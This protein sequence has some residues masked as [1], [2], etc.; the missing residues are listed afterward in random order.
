[1]ECFTRQG[2]EFLDG[3]SEEEKARLIAHAVSPSEFIG[4]AVGDSSA[5]YAEPIISGKDPDLGDVFYYQNV[6]A[7]IAK[8]VVERYGPGSGAFV[9]DQERIKDIMR[10]SGYMARLLVDE[11]IG[12]GSENFQPG[13]IGI[14]VRSLTDASDAYNDY[15][16]AVAGQLV[17]PD[18]VPQ[19]MREIDHARAMEARARKDLKAIRLIQSRREDVPLGEFAQ[20]QGEGGRL[21]AVTIAA[22]IDD[23]RYAEP[24]APATAE[25]VPDMTKPLNSP[26]PPQ[27]SPVDFVPERAKV[28]EF[29]N[30]LQNELNKLGYGAALSPDD[31][32]AMRVDAADGGAMN[33]SRKTS[34]G[35]A[36][37]ND[38]EVLQSQYSDGSADNLS[39]PVDPEV[40]DG[41]VDDAF[42]VDAATGQGI[43]ANASV[44]T[45]GSVRNRLLD[46]NDKIRRDIKAPSLLSI[47]D[48][49]YRGRLDQLRLRLSEL[50]VGYDRAQL[51][52]IVAGYAEMMKPFVSENEA[53][54][55]THG[56]KT[57]S[58]PA[59]N[60]LLT[61]DIDSSVQNQY[62]GKR[63]KGKPLYDLLEAARGEGLFPKTGA[64]DPSKEA[65]LDL[66]FT[67]SSGTV[68]KFVE[69][70]LPVLYPSKNRN[71]A[72]NPQ[73]AAI[74]DELREM[75][76]L[77]FV[78]SALEEEFQSLNYIR[79]DA[80]AVVPI[81]V[82]MFSDAKMPTTI[83]QEAPRR[84]KAAPT[85][86]QASVVVHFGSMS[87]ESLP[88]A[89]HAAF[90]DPD[91]ET[92]VA[93]KSMLGELSVGSSGFAYD[94]KRGVVAVDASNT[95]VSGERTYQGF[96]RNLVA[97]LRKGGAKTIHVPFHIVGDT[98][99]S[100]ADMRVSHELL[101]R[102]DSELSPEESALVSRY[103]QE[104]DKAIQLGILDWPVKRNAWLDAAKLYPDVE[105]NIYAPHFKV[106]D[107]WADPDITKQTYRQSAKF[108]PSLKK[109]KKPLASSEL[110][111]SMIS[112]I[113][114]GK[115]LENQDAVSY[116]IGAPGSRFLRK[117]LDEQGVVDEF[118]DLVRDYKF[119]VREVEELVR[120][121]NLSDP[122]KERWL[123][124]NPL[125]R[126]PFAESIVNSGRATQFLEQA[127]RDV[128]AIEGAIKSSGLEARRNAGPPSKEY[129]EVANAIAGI[130]DAASTYVANVRDSRMK[131]G[132]RD[133][134]WRG[135]QGERLVDF[136]EEP[137]IPQD[138]IRAIEGYVRDVPTRPGVEEDRKRMLLAL[139]GRLE[140][141]TAPLRYREIAE[142][143]DV[144]K[145][146]ERNFSLQKTIGGQTRWA[147]DSAADDNVIFDMEGST[148]APRS[149]IPKF[150]GRKEE[151]PQADF[152]VR[153]E[154]LPGDNVGEIVNAGEW[155]FNVP[156]VASL[157]WKPVMPGQTGVSR[158]VVNQRVSPEAID[159]KRWMIV[160][161]PHYAD[162]VRTAVTSAGGDDA[163]ASA[164][165]ARVR[166]S[167]LLIAST[168]IARIGEKLRGLNPDN[169]VVPTRLPNFGFGLGTTKANL[170]RA[171][172][173]MGVKIANSPQQIAKSYRSLAKD[174]DV[175][176]VYYDGQNRQVK[177][178]INSAL[179]QDKPLI[180][181]HTTPP[182]PGSTQ[183]VANYENFGVTAFEGGNE[184][185]IGS[186]VAR[187]RRVFVPE[188]T[189]LITS[190]TDQS[191]SDP[192]LRHFTA[193]VALNRG[194][195]F[196]V[197]PQ[198]IGRPRLQ[199]SSERV[200]RKPSEGAFFDPPSYSTGYNKPTIEPSMP[201]FRKMLQDTASFVASN[202]TP[203]SS[204]VVW[205]PVPVGY[206][207]PG[208]DFLQGALD[209]VAMVDLPDGY[210]W[211][212]APPLSIMSKPGAPSYETAPYAERYGAQPGRQTNFLG[213]SDT[214]LKVNP[215]ALS[216][217]RRG[218]STSL[219]ARRAAVAELDS[220]LKSSD[221]PR[222]GLNKSQTTRSPE[223]PL[224]SGIRY[225]GET[226]DIRDSSAEAIVN[227]VNVKG[228]MGK[229]L[230]LQMKERWPEMFKAYKSA[231]D[232]G[233]LQIGRMHV[234]VNKASE[235]PR[236]IINFPTKEE[237]GKPSKIEYID[238]GLDALKKELGRLGVKSVAIPKLGSG[239]GGLNW[240]DV[241]ARINA[242][243]GN[244]AGLRVDV[245]ASKAAPEPMVDAPT[246]KTTEAKATEGSQSAAAKPAR[247]PIS[248][249]EP[250]RSTVSKATTGTV[251]QDWRLSYPP[252]LTKNLED[253]DI[254]GELNIIGKD[255]T[256]FQ[257]KAIAVVGSRDASPERINYAR[258]LGVRAAERDVVVVSGLARGVDQAAMLGALESGGR[259]IG[260]AAEGADRI[261]SSAK[262]KKYV[263]NGQLT[264]VSDVGW[265]GD[266]STQNAFRRNKYI[267]GLADSAIVVE[268]DVASGGTKAGVDWLKSYPKTEASYPLYVPHYYADSPGLS[269]IKGK[270]TSVK[271]L[272]EGYVSNQ[273]TT[274]KPDFAAKSEQAAEGAIVAQAPDNIRIL[275][276][277]GMSPSQY[278]QHAKD[279]GYGVVVDTRSYTEGRFH[280]EAIK[281]ELA[282][283]GIAY[284]HVVEFGGKFAGYSKEAY[285]E[286]VYDKRAKEIQPRVEKFFAWAENNDQKIGLMCA[287]KGAH[288]CHNREIFG[289]NYGVPE[290]I[291]GKTVTYTGGAKPG[292]GS[293][294]LY[295][296]LLPFTADALNRP[297]VTGA[298]ARG[299]VGWAIGFYAPAIFW[300]DE[301]EV[302]GTG[303][304]GLQ[305]RVM[306][307]AIGAGGYAARGSINIPKPAM[308]IVPG[309]PIIS[310]HQPKPVQGWLAKA[311]GAAL[312]YLSNEDQTS[313]NNARTF[314]AT[315]E[316]QRPVVNNVPLTNAEWEA[317]LLKEYA[318]QNKGFEGGFGKYNAN[319]S[320]M[321]YFVNVGNKI[322]KR[323]GRAGMEAELY[324]RNLTKQANDRH[325]WY[326]ESRRA[327][328][329]LERFGRIAL[330]ADFELT[331]LRNNKAIKDKVAAADAIKD[332]IITKHIGNDA[333]ARQR[334][335]RFQEELDISR[336]MMVDGIGTRLT[337]ILPS[338]WVESRD[339]LK[340][341]N[342]AIETQSAILKSK[343]VTDPA[344]A[345]QL[346]ANLQIQRKLW[347]QNKA[348]ID[349]FDSLLQMKEASKLFWYMPRRH[350]MSQ[351]KYKYSIMY[352]DGNKRTTVSSRMFD[353]T[354]HGYAWASNQMDA[355]AQANP[356]KKGKYVVRRSQN[357]TKSA[358]LPGNK[359][360]TEK[361]DQ[362]MMAAYGGG[363]HTLD[364]F[365]VSSS[366]VQSFIRQQAELQGLASKE[367]D[368]LMYQA[369]GISTPESLRSAIEELLK[370]GH[371]H[372]MHRN[373]IPGYEPPDGEYG[374]WAL[375]GMH[376][377]QSYGREGVERGVLSKAVAEE[378]EYVSSTGN[379]DSAVRRYLESYRDGV[380]S[381]GYEG[382]SNKEIKVN[383]II[384]NGLTMA[385]LGMNAGYALKNVGFAVAA[386]WGELARDPN[387][388]RS[389]QTA[390]G[391]ITALPAIYGWLKHSDPRIQN[392]MEM[393]EEHDVGGTQ[394][395]DQNLNDL[396]GRKSI[397]YE[398]LLNAGMFLSRVTE[399]FNSR[400]AA[401]T[402]AIAAL[403]RGASEQEAVLHG[404]QMR[405]ASQYSFANH[406][407]SPFERE[408]LQRLP[409]GVG[410]SLNTLLSAAF[411]G[412]EQFS[413]LAYRLRENPK[414]IAPMAAYGALSILLGG[415]YNLPI[416]GDGVRV[417][418][419][420]EELNETL[421]PA[422]ESTPTKR[423]TKEVWKDRFLESTA[424]FLD[425]EWA[426]WLF[427]SVNYGM[428]SVALNKYLGSDATLI[429]MVDAPAINQIARMAK[430][431]LQGTKS[432]VSAEETIY[433]TA[434]VFGT[435]TGRVARAGLQLAAGEQLDSRGT[436]TGEGEY[437]ILDAAKTLALG[438]DLVDQKKTQSRAT[439]GGA[440]YDKLDE[441]NYIAKALYGI[442]G[443][444]IG[445][446]KN[447]RQTAALAQ[448]A[449]Q[450]R[451]EIIKDYAARERRIVESI[452]A[453]DAYMTANRAALSN[454]LRKGLPAHGNVDMQRLRSKVHA[455]IRDWYAAE[456]T[457]E[458]MRKYGVKAKHKYKKTSPLDLIRDVIAEE[459]HHEIPDAKSRY[460]DDD[461]A[462]TELEDSA[463]VER[464]YLENIGR[465]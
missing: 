56:A 367:I 59:G 181:V 101:S 58:D 416:F 341:V 174:A 312:S 55:Y 107:I 60:V 369:Q 95:S 210:K 6:S 251:N 322:F 97:Q 13:T 189:T 319:F 93:A 259:A 68:A 148:D 249:G 180:I 143:M 324:I 197:Q 43:E 450:I 454:A 70:V 32:Q 246:V 381:A 433:R 385:A 428:S 305:L 327:P 401:A 269:V 387:M 404:L 270:G 28:S 426:G 244:V 371:P 449:K 358:A 160:G 18:Q 434:S 278:A 137:K 242:A 173:L 116:L 96:V 144:V 419:A 297:G 4:A 464:K 67:I 338:R 360:S 29:D 25:A 280:R 255:E 99:R 301:E 420:I 439:G 345:A 334:F 133:F 357:T 52:D 12:I 170:G 14:L 192:N 124:L 73:F 202:A 396:M 429:S 331:E 114:D 407:R 132:G 273:P 346:A 386:I 146:N 245:Y 337:G 425:P 313:T 318:E 325:D 36:D 304:T 187:P 22:N 78:F 27:P 263:D 53:A 157:K 438:N 350:D 46:L 188:N 130:K 372:I 408:K 294:A 291:D 348:A 104:L 415:V 69:R 205:V 61:E 417:M 183:R 268:S 198:S 229:G 440:L 370:P 462:E 352:V 460:V 201:E 326:K 47:N 45:E 147:D 315:N 351:S 354:E 98:P 185:L 72:G 328:G 390:W 87:E 323:I 9:G 131:E 44:D 39:A 123:L 171:P 159:G 207:N 215:E 302:F 80:S 90:V 42:D 92:A 267:Y 241:D 154:V 164:R 65:H 262:W 128:K 342:K 149:K 376:H 361:I 248:Q 252:K 363:N 120:V 2:Q 48:A 378:L 254:P 288:R 102:P 86:S 3:L 206:D 365:G 356:N 51:D 31:T 384:K 238:K 200:V 126:L 321:Q 307:G 236:Y 398:R 222:P 24:G 141:F 16:K 182:E 218:K 50:L 227:P 391:G 279:L 112:T 85:E 176:I 340:Q 237:W 225:A 310:A 11:N 437:G 403:N 265:G 156:V 453:A 82:S 175:F 21:G 103:Y 458:T 300:D 394:Y 414:T 88:T 456:A 153:P 333:A 161:E 234:W 266:W 293:G 142:M 193:K 115:G 113:S 284:L 388:L 232:R 199:E 277:A 349:R 399:E 17:P 10:V 41:M 239:L 75:P 38:F 290:E 380:D 368:D 125:G 339:N 211:G 81:N 220:I 74:M 204:G 62:G 15:D 94:P 169:R 452:A 150:E 285:P 5:A 424:S 359:L 221:A 289:R 117:N 167:Q 314:I 33:V 168:D 431:I 448:N 178:V 217:F 122:Q 465:L 140:S 109:T 332:R 392:V 343:M 296:T 264:V 299:A 395:L 292:G 1:M 233:E 40:E 165:F 89:Y 443:L 355:I 209:Q 261:A 412:A 260:V 224:M 397:K 445:N 235:G 106:H 282:D 389:V 212:F 275:N 191:I 66:D 364:A 151:A 118:G 336:E 330:E 461:E 276:Y 274:Q 230:A 186:A 444:T 421:D 100:L 287:C 145:A 409:F 253:R 286:A 228:V 309:T 373:N 258:A 84:K 91:A 463:S 447:P 177:D 271:V 377:M 247:N 76:E 77:R 138:K 427:D 49:A 317:Q 35:E 347:Q 63:P 71:I 111:E 37:E 166:P 418:E 366:D 172:A 208:S 54:F 298:I 110:F 459:L 163:E 295:S 19:R 320:G 442:K 353:N 162:P 79:G 7:A 272:P 281:K 382:L 155:G 30:D 374:A 402:G 441:Y 83:V 405:K 410:V 446:E 119:L 406:D 129:R 311:R 457:V 216:R 139:L 213:P 400:L 219:E 179:Q 108:S 250:A 152:R 64:A 57:A 411:R 413:S 134:D 283:R 231:H 256:V 240:A 423:S 375:T 379:Y 184:P 316:A 190:A 455:Q 136:A 196:T 26:V 362:I 34:T 8:D 135:E 329:E 344:Q 20:D 430:N 257:G 308:Q 435:F 335:L 393:L 451:A 223:A 105:I 158:V 436:P 383:T 194:G 127:R 121:Q 243:L 306:L 214:P 23:L 195:G 203:G 303:I 422:T 432:G 226:R